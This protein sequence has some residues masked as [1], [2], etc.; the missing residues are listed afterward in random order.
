MDELTQVWK[1]APVIYEFCSSENV[2]MKVARELVNSTHPILIH[3]NDYKRDLADLQELMLPVGYRFVLKQAGLNPSV[4]AGDDLSLSMIW[5]NIGT[6]PPYAKMGQR[7]QLHFY[8]VDGSGNSIELNNSNSKDF[9]FTTPEYRIALLLPIPA[10]LQVGEYAL[11]FSIVDQ[12]TLQ[13]IQIAIEGMKQ[14]GR[15]FLHTIQIIPA[16]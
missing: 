11:E 1:D 15:Y 2:D 16:Q 6:A 3:N 7:F 10:G 4:K 13:P 14:D 8:L 9:S 12:R 5:Q